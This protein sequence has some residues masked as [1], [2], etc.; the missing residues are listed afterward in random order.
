[1]HAPL[2]ATTSPDLKKDDLIVIAGAGGFIAGALTR[3][4][5]DQGFTRIRAIDKKPLP[6]WYQRVPGVESLCLDLSEEENCMRAC[7]GAVEV[8]NLAA[9]MGGMGFI[10]RFRVECLRSILINTHMIEAAY[11]AGARR[12]FFSSSACAYNITIQQDPN[13]RALK[14]SDAYPAMA[15]RGYGWEKLMS[16][17]FC[18][19]YW[20]ER[21]L[22][23]AI[24]RFH[25]VYGPHGTWDGGREKAPA[26]ICRK[27]IEAKDSGTQRDRDLGRR[28]ADPQL[29]VHRRLR[30][31]HRH[32]HALRRADRH[33]D[34]P[35][36]QRADLDQ[37]PGRAW[38]K[39][40]A[41]SSS[42]RKYELDAPRGVA[43]RNSDNTFIQSVLGWEPSTPF[44]DGPGARPTPGS[45]SSTRTARPASGRWTDDTDLTGS[46]GPTPSAMPTMVE[47]HELTDIIGGIPYRM[48]FAGGWID[49]PFV[50]QLNPAPPGSMVVVALE[51]TFRF[52]DRC[53]MGTSTRKVAMRLWGG[54]SARPRPRPS[55]CGSSTPRRTAARPSHPVRRT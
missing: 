35:R 13:V 37:R 15:E 53:G 1:M 46:I 45:S 41:A 39:R 18:Q 19:E 24:A 21:G 3:Y 33:A 47:A 4:F 48:A 50:S 30:Q 5:H 9:D 55:W 27:V 36:L 42:T 12:Y 23:T 20:A 29:H 25:N 22:K 6:E 32:D 28:H 38:S 26:A 49:Q 16:E 51:P 54:A 31:G 8:Y 34:Q 7:E 44:R 10:E 43:G 2:T 11:R 52:M 40:S 17:M 14:E